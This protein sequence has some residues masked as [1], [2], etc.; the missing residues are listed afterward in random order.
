MTLF[1]TTLLLAPFSTPAP[2][3]GA[4]GVPFTPRYTLELP[5]WTLNEPGIS[6]W[7]GG[8]ATLWEQ[9]RAT[10]IF[11]PFDQ[12]AGWTPVS[13]VRTLFPFHPEL[14]FVWAQGPWT[15]SVGMDRRYTLDQEDRWK[16]YRPDYTIQEE[17]V[18]ISRGELN[19]IRMTAGY[20]WKES[21]F[22]MALGLDLWRGGLKEEETINGILT[23]Q[24]TD[25]WS[26]LSPV[27]SLSYV[28]QDAV[29]S[30][31][32]Q[33]GSDLRGG[34]DWRL[35]TLVQLTVDLLSADLFPTVV[36]AAFATEDGARWNRQDLGRTYTTDLFLEQNILDRFRF[37]IGGG[38]RGSE[39]S[40]T[41]Y[42]ETAVGYRS[43]FFHGW[44]AESG[45]RVEPLPTTYVSGERLTMSRGTI[46][47][48]FSFQP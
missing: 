2:L 15:M 17:G 20:R 31:L 23:F 18:R 28:K 48:N 13:H 11:D 37:R 36:H 14:G 42:L 35:P 39:G 46:F 5:S 22:S 38:A 19:R 24:Q 47:V 25:H 6:F 10:P 41:G 12:T 26:G 16:V 44:T 8:N 29:F 27:A 30:L 40:W 4:Q 21:P 7:F 34:V 32:I 9:E 1:L 43:G 45:V 3:A 33:A